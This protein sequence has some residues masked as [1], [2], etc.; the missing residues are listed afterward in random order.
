MRSLPPGWRHAFDDRDRH[1]GAGKLDGGDK[2]ADTGSDDDDSVAS[3]TPIPKGRPARIRPG[4]LAAMID[5]TAPT[6]QSR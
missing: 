3:F 6:V 2:A 4:D 1:A 5:R